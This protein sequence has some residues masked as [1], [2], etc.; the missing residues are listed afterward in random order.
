MSYQASLLTPLSDRFTFLS[1][2]D[3]KQLAAILFI[4]VGLFL[5]YHGCR[6]A[7]K[8]ATSSYWPTVEGRVLS[9]SV[10]SEAGKNGGTVYSAE[11]KY[12]YAVNGGNFTAER[13]RFGSINTQNRVY[14]AQLVGRYPAGKS[15]T[16]YYSASDPSVAVLEPGIQS[17]SLLV[18]GVGIIV[19]GMGV[20]VIF[21]PTSRYERRRRELSKRYQG[22]AAD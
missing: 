10:K 17:A 21:L 9:S 2:H 11:V 13:V 3:M 12:A 14:P 8:G 16:I 22:S 19:G 7:I 6:S 1:K 20:A 15:V 4:S 18:S 5:L